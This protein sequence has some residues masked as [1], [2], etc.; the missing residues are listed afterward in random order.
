MKK[1]LVAYFSVSGRTRQVAQ[2]LAKCINADLYEIIPAEPYTDNDIDWRSNKENR[3]SIEMKDKFSR[4]KI[5]N[6]VQDMAKY[7]KIYLGFP[8]WWYVAPRIVN[9]FLESYNMFGKVIVPFGTSGGSGL[10]KTNLIL[11]PSC[12]GAIL[13]DGRVFSPDV[14]ET[15]LK[16]WAMKVIN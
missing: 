1:I 11:S 3:A 10:G 14:D 2:K 6:G 8:I 5:A 13:K 9:T 15:T 16:E 7:D 4:P 12:E